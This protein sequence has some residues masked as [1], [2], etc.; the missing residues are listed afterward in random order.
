MEPHWSTK[1]YFLAKL[2]KLNYRSMLFI[3]KVKG[4]CTLVSF[5]ALFLILG[6]DLF[7]QNT[8]STS[9]TRFWLGFMD[10][11]PFSAS[12]ASYDLKVY[13]SSTV[14]T[15]GTVT[16]TNGYSQNFS[17]IA[18]QTTELTIPVLSAL[19]TTSDVVENK[20]ILIE[21]QENCSVVCINRT[22][23]RF[24]TDGVTVFTEQ[25]L[26]TEYRVTSE[27]G[28]SGI[29]GG[30]S[31]FLIVATED[32][33]QIEI[34][35]KYL[36]MGGFS[37]NIPYTITLNRG[38]SYQVKASNVGSDL[39]GSR[40]RGL[41]GDCKPFAV[42]CG[43]EC[44]YVPY[45]CGTC[46][47]L[48]T[49]CIPVP[50]WSREYLVA[51][52]AGNQSYLLKVVAHSN[53]SIINV[54]GVNVATLNAG[55]S[56]AQ[57]YLAN[58]SLSISS[59]QNISVS[60]FMK[61]SNCNGDVGDPSLTLINPVNLT[62]D[63]VLFKA[64][65]PNFGNQYTNAW[66]SL[67]ANS[68]TTNQ[69]WLDGA[70]INPQ[71]F[72]LFQ[73][74]PLY[75]YAM[76]PI[77][78]GVH[79]LN[80]PNGIHAYLYAY[81]LDE[82]YL[83]SLGA[84][85]DLPL[86]YIDTVICAIDSVMIGNN[87]PMTSIWWSNLSTPND[88]IA[89]GT[90][91][92]TVFPNEETYVLHGVLPNGSCESQFSYLVSAAYDPGLSIN[93][94]TTDICPSESIQLFANLDTVGNFTY[95]WA[96]STGVSNVNSANPVFSPIMNTNYNL[97][98]LNSSGCLVAEDSIH[99]GVIPSEYFTIHI[100]TDDSTL[101]LGDT[102]ML[103]VT[104]ENYYFTETFDTLSN[105]FISN[106]QGVSAVPDCEISNISC[107]LFSGPGTRSF[108]TVPLDVSNGGNLRFSLNAGSTLFS[109]DPPE[110]SDYIILECSLNGGLGWMPIDTYSNLNFTT[111]TE[112][113]VPIIG[114][115]MSSA[116]IFRWRQALHDGLDTD[117]WKLDNL[118]ITTFQESG[119]IVN[120]SAQPSITPL[121][122][123]ENALVY[124]DTTTVYVATFVDTVSQCIYTDTIQIDV[125]PDFNLTVSPSITL[126][127][128]L[129]T[130]LYSMH[131]LPVQPTFQWSPDEFIEDESAQNP[132]ITP[133]MSTMFYLT[134]TSPLG[135]IRR[136][137]VYVSVPAL[138]LFQLEDNMGPICVGDSVQSL[139]YYEP[140]Q[141]LASPSVCAS[142]STL[143][144]I[145]ALGSQ[146]NS[147]N[148]SP[149]PGTPSSK[150]QHMYTVSELNANGIVGPCLI[151]S[152]SLHIYAVYNAGVF[153]NF[154]VKMGCSDNN[155][156]SANFSDGLSV[157]KNPYTINLVSS[158][159]NVINLDIP[160]R[161]DGNS[162]IIIEY[163]YE[164]PFSYANGSYVSYI[165]ATNIGVYKQGTSVCEDDFGIISNN[166]AVIRLEHCSLV[167][168]NLEY[169]WSPSYNISSLNVAE[170][171]FYP[172]TST[173]Y[174]ISAWDSLTGCL[175]EDSIF[176]NV[177]N[178]FTP[179]TINPA[180][181]EICVGDSV[182]LSATSTGSIIFWEGNATLSNSQIIN[183][184][185]FP[186]ITSNYVAVATLD[187]ICFS[188][189]TV[190]VIVNP[191][192]NADLG[193]D[194]VM[195]LGE[196]MMI[197]VQSDPLST[198]FWSSGNVPI[199]T[200][201]INLVS[202]NLPTSYILEVIDDN[203]CQ[204][205][206][207]IQLIP[208]QGSVD[209]TQHYVVICVGDSI[210][211]G[212]EFQSTAGF[213]YDTLSNNT[214]CDSILVTQLSFTNNT[215]SVSV[216]GVNFTICPGDSVQLSATINGTYLGWNNGNTLSNDG[217]SSPIAFPMISTEY[218]VSVTND[219]ICYSYDTVTVFVNS[220]PPLDLGPG[221]WIC[222]GDSITVGES[223]QAQSTYEWLSSNVPFVNQSSNSV[224][225]LSATLY[226]LEKT[227]TA[228]CS[229][230]DSLLVSVG[231]VYVIQASDHYI[232]E[233][234]SVFLQ[235]AYQSSSGTYY[236]TLSTIY[237]CDSIRIQ[238]LSLL[239]LPI[240]DFNNIGSDTVCSNYPP[241]NLPVGFPVGGVYS[242]PG[243]SGNLFDPTQAG[244]GSHPVTYSFTDT[245]G[246]TN[247]DTVF[248][249]VDF[250]AGIE[251]IPI[252]SFGIFPNPFEEF[253]TIYFPADNE[254][255]DILIYDAIGR[256]VYSV[257]GNTEE[258][259]QIYKGALQS[260]VYHVCILDT[261]GQ[262]V[263]MTELLAL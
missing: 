220:T 202:P 194:V 146:A 195:C 143:S 185:A 10:N 66:L 217:V 211:L 133:A 152:V 132:L 13:V 92:I 9:G 99:I 135:C 115:M 239:P 199:D 139:L 231:S 80:A 26:G 89:T 181:A 93:G 197:G 209:T 84:S 227:D 82:S 42:F 225:P 193:P 177:V 221:V 198:Y 96:P 257:P 212:G 255:R 233:G 83:L 184:F 63:T 256:L 119:F 252:S 127:N 73:F 16:I 150:L 33:T 216:V 76:I 176:I 34:T 43:S 261:G 213:Y 238:P 154:S 48:L 19:H 68:Q 69:V 200:I 126:C 55:Q 30:Q 111:W 27:R 183:P 178:S 41:S 53:N 180:S 243:V 190:P 31:E 118:A 46:D 98:V 166:K 81:G 165:P 123:G 71:E 147:A 237:G 32:N 104:L 134:A 14:N 249:Y 88:T 64:D 109:C 189:D 120:W 205:S 112:V 11:A 182:Q 6:Q 234:D 214:G 167:S 187:S 263:Y 258:Q 236:D 90:P 248:F 39:T 128:S 3:S 210:F 218:I 137:S 164:N 144:T 47:H 246:C 130:Y 105:N 204:G 75:S 103:H 259:V 222:P 114:N 50:L 37:Q 153:N 192:P 117:I 232:C 61:G 148:V 201:S 158:N 7:A 91:Y 25:S 260:G 251:D 242:G 247:T 4:V 8:L 131:D 188:R 219:S 162:N 44:S 244:L 110:I 79:V 54:N 160:F 159:W 208:S 62:V 70:Q 2:Q 65:F 179:V 95:H 72:Q 1:R 149:F 241:F 245:A 122:L 29:T 174:Y 17:V 129:G 145:G 223:P 172:D 100:T 85:N 141:C 56:F 138:N 151:T 206:D 155:N 106:V 235:G 77:D 191:L 168:S 228:G 108:E 203:G 121:N 163:C 116:T 18:N 87:T 224:N 22:L 161:W 40:V 49:Q 59:N 136:D 45:T 15:S 253:T 102:N 38:Q 125:A 215:S 86:N 142:N 78:S 173:T 101:C 94:L 28:V 157:V 240:V 156:M 254:S 97:Q 230:I 24:S 175:Y 186:V 170:P 262:Q 20:G 107:L 58:S 250:C 229:S 196:T 67:V 171:I 169:T 23:P 60:Q 51:P 12:F 140:A 52:L 57:S 36:T 226:V 74:A 35:P 21:T 5:L 124:P 113:T 207:T